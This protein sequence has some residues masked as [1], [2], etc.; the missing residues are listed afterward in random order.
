MVLSLA[1][2]RLALTS[3]SVPGWVCPH[4]RR[5]KLKHIEDSLSIRDTVASRHARDRE[6][7]GEGLSVEIG[8]FALFLECDRPVCQESVV[9]CGIATLE[10]IV[11]GPGQLQISEVLH[12]AFIDPPIHFFSIPRACPL[13][14][15]KE[16]VSCFRL[17]WT[18]NSAAGNRLRAAV[19]RL[20]DHL[21]IPSKRKNSRGRFD[22]LSLHQRIEA[23][24]E[25]APEVGELLLAVKWLGNVASHGDALR[26]ADL[27]D[28]F[29]ILQ[30]VLD[31][32][33]TR[34]GQ[35]VAQLAKE[36][37]KR[38]GPRSASRRRTK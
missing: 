3:E 18:D 10:M 17:V 29:E 21:K 31:I 26:R 23:L 13:S 5:G 30:Y 1:Q 8:R 22:R 14:V 20:L 37:N 19:E 4:C 24:R 2:W 25:K 34:R 9:V 6:E 12:P 7:V 36:I 27:V 28:G 32:V 38:K 33:L 15:S 11:L 35:A 16:L